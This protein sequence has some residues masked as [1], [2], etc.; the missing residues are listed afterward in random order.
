V[1]GAAT[2]PAPKRRPTG[3]GLFRSRR[4]DFADESLSQAASVT[5]GAV[6]LLFTVMVRSVLR[7]VQGH[8]APSH[9][10]LTDRD[11]DESSRRAISA[12]V[13]T[14]PQTQVR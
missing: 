4:E 6:I 11:R 3:C 5:H 7:H 9:P 10:D 14:N 12:W 1:H 8:E 13:R 2:G